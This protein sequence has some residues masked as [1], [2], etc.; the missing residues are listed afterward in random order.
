MVNESFYILN[1]HFSKETMLI[2]EI[3]LLLRVDLPNHI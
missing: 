3:L 1:I 2:K